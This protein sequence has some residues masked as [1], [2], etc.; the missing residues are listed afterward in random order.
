[1]VAQRE[2]EERPAGRDQLHRR[3]QAALHDGDVAGREVA[4]ELVDV[5]AHLEPVGARQR[6][7]GRCAGP[8]TTIMRR[9]GTRSRAGGSAAIDAAQQRRADAGAA[10]GDDA[11]RLVR[12]S[13]ARARSAA[14]SASASGSKP[15]T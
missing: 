8:A 12:R 7:P 5:A 11:D 10:D 9:P 14:R 2:G 13:R 3:R 15:G 6:S 4:V 1:M